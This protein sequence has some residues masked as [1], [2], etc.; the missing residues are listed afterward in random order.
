[1]ERERERERLGEQTRKRRATVQVN[2][3]ATTSVPT[4]NGGQR[5][6]RGEKKRNE[7]QANDAG[8]KQTD[9]ETL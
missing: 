9:A 8:K 7:K 1:M 3:Q 4:E 6:R 5:R 2:T